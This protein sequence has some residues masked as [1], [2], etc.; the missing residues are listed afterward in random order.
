MR[1]VKSH[2]WVTIHFGSSMTT[3]VQVLECNLRLEWDEE[4]EKEASDFP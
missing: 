2:K 3:A 1:S 4:F